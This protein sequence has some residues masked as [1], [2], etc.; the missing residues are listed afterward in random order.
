VTLSKVG[1]LKKPKVVVQVVMVVP[2]VIVVQLN[3][4][5][6]TAFGPQADLHVS[7]ACI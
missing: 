2:V 1:H 3:S 4:L 5:I 6:C 7:G